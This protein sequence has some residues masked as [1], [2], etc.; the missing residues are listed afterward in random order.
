MPQIEH[1][2]PKFKYRIYWKLDKPGERWKIEDIAD[3][4]L[5][6][7]VIPNQP[8]YQRYKIKVVAHNEK[9]EANVAAEEVTTSSNFF[10]IRPRRCCCENKLE[11][12][13]LTSF[14]QYG[15]MFAVPY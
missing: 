13:F 10:L 11:R 1:N 6:E 7:L 4:R 14:F 9:G 5:K 15:R 8:T 3:W 2:A 12:L